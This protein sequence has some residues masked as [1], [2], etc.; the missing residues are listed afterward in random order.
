MASYITAWSRL[1]IWVAFCQ[2]Q[3]AHIAGRAGVALFPAYSY[4]PHYIDTLFAALRGLLRQRRG[5]RGFVDAPFRWD[6]TPR[7]GFKMRR[8]AVEE[9]AP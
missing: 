3:P 7:S 1:A 4:A 9:I 8:S 2:G 5:T 6:Y